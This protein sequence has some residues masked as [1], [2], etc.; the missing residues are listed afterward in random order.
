MPV[1]QRQRI[2]VAI[3][4]AL[5]LVLPA[6]ADV[7]MTGNFLA[8]S[9]C[10][11]LQSFNKNTNPGN[12][13]L[14]PEQ[15]YQ[16]VSA[17][18]TPASHYMVIVPGA[19]PE[20]RWVAVS[21]GTTLTSSDAITTAPS[22][23]TASP[24]ET[25]PMPAPVP[26]APA[27]AKGAAP[28]H[29]VLAISWEPGFC[30]GKPGKPEC[31]AE[32]ASSF[33]ASHFTLHGLW[34]D[35]KEYCGAAAADIAA[36]KAGDWASLPAVTLSTATRAHLDT[37]MP[38]TQ[39]QLERHEWI[40]H[41]TCSGASMEAYFGRELTFLDAVNGSP[42]Q[43]LFAGNIGKT[44]GLAQIRAAF[45]QGFGAGAGQRIRLSC[46]RQAGQR[47]ITEI[48][49]GLEG[50]VMGAAPIQQLIAAAG[51]TSGGCD[52]GVIVPAGN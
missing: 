36:D 35:P 52:S 2:A 47:D 3:F 46:P 21:C 22:A 39:S 8:S 38:G 44:V 48:T 34:P 29:F 17:N 24:T 15:M 1:T 40:K 19:D 5:G 13:T 45:E 18:K 33:E 28:T 12:I 7:P 20:R 4:A 41:G 6:R 31:A 43:A 42:V 16:L 27:S 11:A 25:K 14:K 26:V 51:P 50:D 32:T 23:T 49:I 30:A 37:A 9:A 10:P